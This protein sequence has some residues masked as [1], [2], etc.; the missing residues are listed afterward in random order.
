MS[1]ATSVKTTFEAFIFSLNYLESQRGAHSSQPHTSCKILRLTATP[2]SGLFFF[3]FFLSK[4]GVFVLV[5]SSGAG[6][7][8]SVCCDGKLRAELPLMAA[9]ERSEGWF[10][11]WS[12]VFFLRFKG[13]SERPVSVHCCIHWLVVFSSFDSGSVYLRGDKTAQ[14]LKWCDKSSENKNAAAVDVYMTVESV[15]GS[16]FINDSDVCAGRARLL[17]WNVS[18]MSES[19]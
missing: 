17:F 3:S 9:A 8:V 12:H 2:L 16:R 1:H 15:R 7:A 18:Q 10:Y 14:W 6:G 11:G 19:Y 4:P 13:L 5:A